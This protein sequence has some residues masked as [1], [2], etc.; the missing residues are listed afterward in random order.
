[1]AKWIASEVDVSLPAMGIKNNACHAF[2]L[3]ALLLGAFTLT[4]QTAV[5]GE[6]NWLDE[7][8]VRQAM[9]EEAF[10]LL[11]QKIDADQN[12]SAGGF[13]YHIEQAY[14]KIKKRLPSDPLSAAELEAWL[15]QFLQNPKATDHDRE[16]QILIEQFI[17]GMSLEIINTLQ[18]ECEQAEDLIAQ[19]DKM[20]GEIKKTPHPYRETL[21]RA[22]HESSLSKKMH[23]I[24]KN[25]DRRWRIPPAGAESFSAFSIWKTDMTGRSTD[26]DLRLVFDLGDRYQARYPF[27]EGF[28]GQ[29]RRLAETFRQT[30]LDLNAMLDSSSDS[31]PGARD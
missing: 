19:V 31:D 24:V 1:M 30:V 20:A 13:D 28:L 21:D 17:I 5:S 14:E 3:V 7:N 2:F 27:L 22:L 18:Y 25:I 15:R 16:F 26:K 4:G 6:G 10:R 12:G 23:G 9:H 29:Y 8:Q 11:A